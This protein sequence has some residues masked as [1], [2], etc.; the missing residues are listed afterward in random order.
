M[1]MDIYMMRARGNWLGSLE[2]VSC[3]ILAHRETCLR[4]KDEDKS[5]CLGKK[6]KGTKQSLGTVVESPGQMTGF[7]IPQAKP[8]AKTQ[9]I[10]QMDHKLLINIQQVLSN[11]QDSVIPFIR[12]W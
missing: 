1:D 5:T 11:M 2:Y 10:T 9:L 3:L 6:N 7:R 4:I 8:E 12:H